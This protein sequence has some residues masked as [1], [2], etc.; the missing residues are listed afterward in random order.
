MTTPISYLFAA[1]NAAREII[2]LRTD[3]LF[4]ATTAATRRL[5]RE[6]PPRH[7]VPVRVSVESV[8]AMACGEIASIDIEH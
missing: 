8:R 3:L 1:A 6:R 5:H 4:V 7:A 2:R